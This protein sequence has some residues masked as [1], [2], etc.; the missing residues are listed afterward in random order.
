MLLQRYDRGLNFLK[1]ALKAE[2]GRSSLDPAAFGLQ[3]GDEDAAGA[4]PD[5]LRCRFAN[6]SLQNVWVYGMQ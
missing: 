2:G 5:R 6:A 1:A 3:A 4:A